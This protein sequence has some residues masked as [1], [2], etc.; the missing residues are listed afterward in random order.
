MSGSG[1]PSAAVTGA[2]VHPPRT[3]TVFAAAARN[4]APVSG[5]KIDR[6][7]VTIVGLERCRCRRIGFVLVAALGIVEQGGNDR[8]Q[9]DHDDADNDGNPRDQ[10]LDDVHVAIMARRTVKNMYLTL[11]IAK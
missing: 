8:Q 6:V 7:A 3:T 11:A 9:H 10:E 2:S 5:G 4:E 1:Y